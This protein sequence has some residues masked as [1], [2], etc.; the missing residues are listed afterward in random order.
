MVI[1]VTEFFRDPPV[2]AQLR[3]LLPALAAGKRGVRVW[4]AGCSDGAELYSVAMLLARLALLETS[5]LWGSDC[6][7]DAVARARAGRF[8]PDQ[9]KHLPPAWREEFL[10]PEG[11][12]L[13][14][15]EPLRRAAVWRVADLL[16]E[17]S[18]A[19]GP[20]DVI[21]CRNVAI[22]LETAASAVLWSRLADRLAE[23]GIL[24]TGNAER[25]E[26]GNRLE[27]MAP[28][29]FRKVSGRTT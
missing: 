15:C 16:D 23:G 24:V 19:P 18:L 8:L 25:A 6:R 2:F 12:R 21:L 29:I 22:Y 3:A 4:S 13:R 10:E 5:R 1:G 14:I 7:P 28:C 9:V 17:A 26:A 20:W 11:N 27:R